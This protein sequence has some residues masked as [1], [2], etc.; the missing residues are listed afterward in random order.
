MKQRLFYTI[1]TAAILTAP[2]ILLGMWDRP[3]LT[4][5]A[6]HK[7]EIR[8]RKY[9]DLEHPMSP[10]E[11]AEGPY[12]PP[13]VYEGEPE[14]LPSTVRESY[15]YGVDTDDCEKVL[16]HLQSDCEEK[17]MIFYDQSCCEHDRACEEIIMEP[18]IVM[19][20]EEASKYF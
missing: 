2:G 5:E 8:N 10:A 11:Y 18:Q 14:P 3:V 4:T 1:T 17:Q 19:P 9:H 12:M 7:L 6:E 13:M 20:A 15:I 16:H